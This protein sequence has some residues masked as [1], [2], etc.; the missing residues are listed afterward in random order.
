MHIHFS[1][2][3]WT[4]TQ[5]NR[6][7]NDVTIRTAYLPTGAKK[8]WIDYETELPNGRLLSYY[9]YVHNISQAPADETYIRLQIWR[10]ATVTTGESRFINKLNWE[11]RIKIQLQEGLVGALYKVSK[12]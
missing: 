10:P 1:G 12:S 8:S 11:K 3:S 2:L 6:Y 7:G 5:A 9:F 4:I